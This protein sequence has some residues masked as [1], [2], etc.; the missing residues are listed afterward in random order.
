MPASRRLD[1][2]QLA[3]LLFVALALVPAGAHF[4]ELPNKMRLAPADYMAVQ[5]I[6]RGWAL[7]GIVLFGALAL[8]IVHTVAIRRHPRAMRLSLGATLCVVANLAIFF[9]FTYPMN[10]AT[11][12]WTVTPADFEAARAQWEY[13]HAVNAVVMLLAFLATAMS[14]LASRPAVAVD[15]AA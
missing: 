8:L 12:N 14:V 3:T 4:F 10:V 5:A 15:A 13:S 6:Y 7:F 11:A 2:L 9:A 1:L